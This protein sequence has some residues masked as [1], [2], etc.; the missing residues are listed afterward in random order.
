MAYASVG[1]A[2]H[3]AAA[4]PGGR[5]YDPTMTP[6]ERAAIGNA[7]WMCANHGTLIDRDEATYTR[8]EITAWRVEHEARIKRELELGKGIAS[9]PQSHQDLIALG[10]NVIALGELTGAQGS[11][12][13]LRLDHFVVGDT[14]ALTKLGEDFGTLRPTDRF[15]LINTEGDGR[16]ISSPLTWR[17]DNGVVA[18]ELQVAP[19]FPRI[20]ADDLG[21]DIKL[22]DGDLS[23]EV[24][25][26]LDLLPQRLE[27][28]MSMMNGQ[29]WIGG[30]F[31]SRVSEYFALYGGTPWFSR[32]LKLEAIR[33]AAIP[34]HDSMLKT[35]YTHFQCVERVLE[36]DLLAA[37]PDNERLS[38]RVKLDVAG[39]G[40][41]TRD[42]AV[43]LSEYPPRPNPLPSASD[44]GPFDPP[45]PP[46]GR[47]ASTDPA[48]ITKSRPK[49]QETKPGLEMVLKALDGTP[50]EI[51]DAVARASVF[52]RYTVGGSPKTQFSV[53]EE[54]LLLCR[55]ISALPQDSALERA[56][57]KWLA[58]FGEAPPSGNLRDLMK[59]LIERALKESEPPNPFD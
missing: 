36:L 4:A 14:A 27:V 15:V 50:A 31:G 13:R 25:S 2:A 51:Q 17:R 33:L 53:G 3:I 48:A 57:V 9:A 22:V 34:H 38:I 35:D 8:P 11:A 26:G 6:E 44:F 12:W 24:V 39:V 46:T 52:I 23:N 54:V 5:R 28:V 29:E 55:A 59:R 58:L 43:Y 40:P 32:M 7:I 30:D 18:V 19:R 16:A 42:L 21:T 45:L 10:P 20:K 56:R 1:V 49:E 37:H 47:A 41:W